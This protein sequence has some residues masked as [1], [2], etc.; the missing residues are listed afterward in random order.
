MDILENRDGL[1]KA[2]AGRQRGPP[3]YMLLGISERLGGV[4]DF[5]WAQWG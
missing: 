5:G 2:R 1:R 4:A 3:R